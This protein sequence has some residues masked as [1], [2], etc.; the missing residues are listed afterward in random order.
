MF[1]LFVLY[2]RCYRHQL[3]CAFNT[4]LISLVLHSNSQFVKLR[5]IR[6]IILPSQPISFLD[7]L[8]LFYF[9]FIFSFVTSHL[10]QT[11]SHD[12][13]KLHLSF[14]SQ[15]RPENYSISSPRY[16]SFEIGQRH[17]MT[18]DSQY[19]SREENDASR[20]ALGPETHPFFDRKRGRQH[21][22]L[23]IILFRH[24][25]TTQALVFRS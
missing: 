19:L 9:I 7:F 12:P 17:G 11:P 8:F 1:D 5:W 16:T 6:L 23:R 18:E 14:A 25:P 15:H 4:F 10:E 2:A 13:F 3:Y 22:Q 21:L 24:L 20:L